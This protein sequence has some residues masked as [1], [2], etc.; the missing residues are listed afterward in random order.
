[1]TPPLVVTG[2]SGFIGRHFLAAAAAA[3]TPVRA[4]TRGRQGPPAG[5]AEGAVEW[6]FGDLDD[7]SVWQRLLV[8]GCT[9]VNLAYAQV[10]ATEAAVAAARAMAAACAAAGVARIIH[11]ST[12]S[13]FGRTAGGVID[14]TTPCHPVDDYGRQ[15]LAIEE[16][17]RT[18]DRGACELA[19]L[20]PA[21][22]FGAGGQALRTLVGSLAGGSRLANY[23]R[24]SLFGR[25]AMHLVPVETVVA[26]LLFLCAR[27]EALHG[28]LFIVA[29]DDDPLNNFRDV[30]RTLMSALGVA[31]YPLP[32]LPLPAG[33]L[34]SLLRAR[35]R[36]E[37]DPYCRYS[38]AKLRG[39]GFVPPIGFADALRA[40]A[41]QAAAQL[42]ESRADGAPA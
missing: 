18:A 4:L 36:S 10:A 40:F 7:P 20:R 16:A 35:G 33:V 23:A 1:M 17:L 28:E 26:A 42:N 2:A 11:C 21:A 34:A 8:E 27:R 15:K 9:V 41:A 12:I 19:I 32:P 13:V 25:R 14:E 3:G 39:A 5:V 30:E 31:D 22:V 6:V 24:A 38:A 37:I 29:E